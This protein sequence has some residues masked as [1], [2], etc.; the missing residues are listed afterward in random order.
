MTSRSLTAWQKPD[1]PLCR[2]TT[3]STTRIHLRHSCVALQRLH[4]S[5][6]LQD[7][8]YQTTRPMQRDAIEHRIDPA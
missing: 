5:E 3:R 1:G 7:T 2:T 4:P 8:F 6:V